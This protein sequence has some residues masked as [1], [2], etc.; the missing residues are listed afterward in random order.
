MRQTLEVFGFFVA[1]KYVARPKDMIDIL[2]NNIPFPWDYLIISCHGENGAILMPLLAESIYEPDEPRGNFS[3]AEI[4]RYCKLSGKTVLN[5]GCT[6]GQENI[7]G[8]F[9][10][11]NQYIAPTDYVAGNS[12]LY[13]A[14]RFFYEIAQNG[15]TVHDAWKLASNADKETFSF[16][17]YSN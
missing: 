7:A 9:A 4:E 1:T 2:E 3:A 8:V 13:F 15:R 10:K 14:V 11:Q 12:A 17:Y 5:L 16:A 6:T